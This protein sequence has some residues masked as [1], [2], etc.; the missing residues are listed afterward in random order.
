[1]L[2]D[3]F[4]CLQM[5][6]IP[7]LTV[8]TQHHPI[9]QVFLEELSSYRLFHHNRKIR[10]ALTAL[11]T[12][13]DA[14]SKPLPYHSSFS[15]FSSVEIAIVQMVTEIATLQLKRPTESSC[16]LIFLPGVSFIESLFQKL[17]TALK[18]EQLDE[19]LAASLEILVLH[20]LVEKADKQ[21]VFIPLSSGMTRVVLAT[22]VAESSVTIPFVRYVIDLGMHRSVS[23]S[24]KERR[25]LLA[26][27]WI[28]KS[29]VKQRR[30]RTGRM[31][32]GVH[33]CLFTHR[34][35]ESMLAFAIPEMLRVSL[36]A[37]VLSLKM[38]SRGLDP[39]SVFANP[40]KAL[41]LAIQ[42]PDSEDVVDAIEELFD[43][44][45][46]LNPSNAV[47]SVDP[48]LDDQDL[49]VKLAHAQVTRFGE[50]CRNIPLD[51]S[52]SKLILFGARSGRFINHAVIIAVGMSMPDL[53]VRPYPFAKDLK[54][55]FSCLESTS[56][57]RQNI[58]GQDFSDALLPLRLYLLSQSPRATSELISYCIHLPRLK[59]LKHT[60]DEISRILQPLLPAHH[61]WLSELRSSSSTILRLQPE[62][63]PFCRLMIAATLIPHHGFLL[64]KFPGPLQSKKPKQPASS[65]SD[66]TAPPVS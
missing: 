20:G 2:C 48:G 37:A 56:L 47:S 32:P 8:G 5:A 54:N 12:Y 25:T 34:L 13:F 65:S 52:L 39:Q 43:F 49:D 24:P 57:G 9:E 18:D 50:L 55:Y 27:E 66:E 11:R 41:A 58:S 53:F 1:M 45:I 6:P 17:D 21:R 44:N 7:F 16:V 36:A 10:D 15:I 35:H 51:F 22:N 62:D 64:G 46:L 23:H 4:A 33:F 60:V 40:R 28:S 63:L 3:Y 26:T 31:C 42:P 19:A 29:N 59:V 61:R 30:G 14:S 38:L